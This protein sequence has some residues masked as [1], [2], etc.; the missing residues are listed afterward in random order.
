MDSA[1]IETPVIAR[2]ADDLWH[3]GELMVPTGTEV[4]GRARADHLRERIVASG[5]WTFVW[6]SG[7]SSVMNRSAHLFV[8]GLNELVAYRW[9][10]PRDPASD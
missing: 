6:R 2:V 1:N 9:T 8:R 4:H 5:A 3:N 7:A 10:D